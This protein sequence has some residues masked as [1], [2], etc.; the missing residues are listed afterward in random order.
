[1]CRRPRGGGKWVRVIRVRVRVR[2]NVD[3][4]GI[5]EASEFSFVVG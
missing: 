4:N 2:V 3:G 5:M 1:M